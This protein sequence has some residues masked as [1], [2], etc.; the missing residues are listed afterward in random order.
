M[1]HSELQ[2][3]PSL[4]KQKIFNDTVEGLTVFVENKNIDGTYENL[5]I[6]DDSNI[7]T[8]VSS[9]S[10]TI[11]AKSGIVDKDNKK[12]ILKNGNIQRFD[13]DGSVSIIKFDKTEL[14]LSGLSTK[15]ISEPK[16]QET[17]TLEILNCIMVYETYVHF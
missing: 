13:V 12:L 7:L 2:F 3:V 16:I 5:F 11:F 15:S 9:N 6:R 1:K 17:S 14:S 10:S 4:L 8:Q